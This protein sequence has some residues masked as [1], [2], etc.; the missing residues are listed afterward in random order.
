MPQSKLVQIEA[1]AF[2]MQA[3]L[4]EALAERSRISRFTQLAVFSCPFNKEHQE[5]PV[6]MVF[7][8]LDRQ[9]DSMVLIPSRR[10]W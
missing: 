8:S 6:S 7:V 1:I 5:V 10:H 3:L 9:Q 2:Q 4:G